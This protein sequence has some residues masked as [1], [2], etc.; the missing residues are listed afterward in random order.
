MTN[1]I[2]HILVAYATGTGSTG[3][4][5]EAIAGVLRDEQVRVAVLRVQDVPGVSDYSAVVLGSS[6]RGGRWLPEAI[7]FLEKFA[8]VLTTRPVAYFTT[9]LTMVED[10]PENRR[11]VRE[12]LDPVLALAPKIEPVGLGLF[13]GSLNPAMKAIVPGGGPYGDF[14]NWEL[15]REWAGQ[16]K[17]HLLAPLLPSGRKMI[18]SGHV[19]SFT[20]LSGLDLHGAVMQ[21]T[22]LHAARLRQTRLQGADLRSADLTGADLHEAELV[23]AGLGWADLSHADLSEANLRRANLIGCILRGANLTGADLSDALLNGA[24]LVAVNLAGAN[25]ARADLNW[26]V[27]RE[28]DLRGANLNHASLGWV[29]FTQSNVE[30]AILTE[31]RYNGYTKWPP[32]FSPEAAGCVLVRGP[33]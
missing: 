32:G 11:I 16:I 1:G 29:D 19:L 30:A 22:E 12:Y 6:I 7:D 13:A 26:A 15:I 25:L 17:P 3:E 27:L 33:H 5:A 23:E 24:D 2:P 18:L 31:A 8:G 10:T 14:R 9:C 28:A 21:D 4:V 20:D